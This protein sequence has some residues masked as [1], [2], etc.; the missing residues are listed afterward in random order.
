MIKELIQQELNKNQT[1]YAR[2]MTAIK[3]HRKQEFLESFIN[4]LTDL[5]KVEFFACYSMG[6]EPDNIKLKSNKREIVWARWFVWW[7]YR[8]QGMIFAKLGAFYGKDHATV[9]SGLRKLKLYTETNDSLFCEAFEEFKRQLIRI[10][11]LTL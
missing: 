3:N 8:R 10:E 2:I 4:D 11:L 7:Y 5:D 6:I 9:M 1:N